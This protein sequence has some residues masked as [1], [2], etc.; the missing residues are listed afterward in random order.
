MIRSRMSGPEQIGGVALATNLSGGPVACLKQ[1]PLSPHVAWLRSHLSHVD[2][3]HLHLHL[4]LERG[5][6][7][8]IQNSVN[9]GSVFIITRLLHLRWN[10]TPYLTAPSAQSLRLRLCLLNLAVANL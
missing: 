6:T 1:D 8:P 3:L 4:H 10:S 9:R 2:Q 7:E 5:R